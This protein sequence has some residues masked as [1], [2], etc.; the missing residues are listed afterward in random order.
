[1]T[2]RR[3]LVLLLAVL[4]PLGCSDSTEP[5]ATVPMAL[6]YISWPYSDSPQLY[7]VALD[8]SSPVP[9][10]SDSLRDVYEVTP[11]FPPW[12][13]TNGDAVKVLAWSASGAWELLKLNQFGE[14]QSTEPYQPVAGSMYFYGYDPPLAPD[15]TRRAWFSGGY[16][17]ISNA[18]GTGLQQTYF[19]SLGVFSGNVAWSRDGKWL[20]YSMGLRDDF[21]VY[22][23]RNTRLWILRLSDGFKRPVTSMDRGGSE[24]A[25]SRDG[26]W[27]TFR[28]GTGINRVRTDGDFSEQAVFIGAVGSHAW[29]P[30]DALIAFEG[31]SSGLTVIRADG[32]GARR[33]A[34]GE[35]VESFA[36]AQ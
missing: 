1:M 32:S 31:S 23:V 17:N 3:A 15:G 4:A 16:L 11:Y 18:D 13:S 9:L 2:P 30:E 25:W 27:L 35:Y 6:Y 28:S 34:E 36:W 14:L 19:D 29:G 22:V 12:V 10:L 26:K 8:G 21:N 20:A 5:S 7:A 33:V 24:L